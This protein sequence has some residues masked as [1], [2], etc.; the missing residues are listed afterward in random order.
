MKFLY[1]LFIKIRKREYKEYRR[2]N[3]TKVSRY[4]NESNF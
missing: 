2:K 3:F 4:M 1:Y